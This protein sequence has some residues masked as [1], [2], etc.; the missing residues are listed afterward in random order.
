[1][2]M[3]R[4][5]TIIAAS[6]MLLA[7]S[8]SKS[9]PTAQ[10]EQFLE[11]NASNLHGDWVLVAIQGTPVAEGSSFRINFDRS[12]QKFK[13]WNSMSSI[14]ASY[15]YSEGTFDFYDDELGRYIRGID[16]SGE[17]WRDMYMVKDLTSNQMIWVGKNDPTFVQTFNRIKK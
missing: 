4:I 10:A 15:D 3:N 13:I 6:A 2:K 7:A 5:F 8:C 11:V 12:G 17:E 1:M 14:P 9:D 16:D